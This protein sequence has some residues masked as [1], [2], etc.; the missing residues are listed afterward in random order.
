MRALSQEGAGRGQEV[1]VHGRRLIRAEAR[2]QTGSVEA[3]EGLEV[4]GP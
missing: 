3:E 2:D 1:S 4:F